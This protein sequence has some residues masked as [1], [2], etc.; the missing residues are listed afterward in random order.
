MSKYNNVLLIKPQ[1][2]NG[3]L[4]EEKI[5]S[6]DHTCPCCKGNGWFWDDITLGDTMKKSCNACGGTGKVDAEITI[7]WTG[8]FQRKITH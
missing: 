4:L 7:K 3:E 6:P 1:N 5:F 8:A 2:L